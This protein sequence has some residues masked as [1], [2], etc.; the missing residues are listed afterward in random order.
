MEKCLGLGFSVSCF[1][2]CLV[3]WLL[4]FGFLGFKDFGFLVSKNF[5]FLVSKIIGFL[6]SRILGF[7]VSKIYRISRSCF[8][9]EIDIMSK[10]SKNLKTDVHNCCM[11]VFSETVI[12]DSQFFEI[13]KQNVFK[14]CSRIFLDLFKYPGVSKNKNKWFWGSGTRSKIPKS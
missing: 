14:Q 13:Y 8:L 1:L 10:I 2:G 9:E 5:G 4:G 3:S 11:P 6:V 7:K 12:W